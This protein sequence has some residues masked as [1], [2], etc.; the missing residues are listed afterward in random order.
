MITD[1]EFEEIINKTRI[2]V[3]KYSGIDV[4]A[5]KTRKSSIVTNATKVFLNV[6]NRFFN[7]IEEKRINDVSKFLKYKR[8]NGWIQINNVSRDY[9]ITREL[10]ELSNI[11]YEQVKLDLLVNK[12]EDTI[13]ELLIKKIKKLK[14][15]L[16]IAKDILQKL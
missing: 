13:K 8:S 5:A 4:N 3:I 2:Y 9:K 10:I 6:V 1:E 7:I 15:E 11:I 12:K 16:I 14:E